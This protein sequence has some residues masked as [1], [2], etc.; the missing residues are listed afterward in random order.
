ME[1]LKMKL[2]IKNL[3]QGN[4]L[5]WHELTIAVEKAI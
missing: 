5:S 4:R 3:K 2:K 1:L